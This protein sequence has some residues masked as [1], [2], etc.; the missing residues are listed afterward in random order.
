MTVDNFYERQS[1]LTAAK[2]E[3]YK[4]YIEGY[5]PRLLIQ[6]GTCLI[7][8]LF[9]GAGK[10]GDK[11]G[12]PLVLID[13]SKYILSSPKLQ[14]KQIQIL[15]NDHD[16]DNIQNLNWVLAKIEIEANIQIFKT[17]NNKF[18]EL[19]P[20]LIEKL[21]NSNIPK[22]F[23]LDPFTYSNIKMKHLKQL[24]ALP[25]TEI[26]LFLPIFHSYR[27]ASDKTM[28]GDHKTRLFI[29]EFTTKGVADYE[30][31]DEFMFSVKEK[32]LKKLS[33]DFVRP[34]LLNDGA[35]KNSLFLLTKHQAGM[36]LMNKIA[37][38]MSED[39]SNVNIKTKNQLSLFGV[40]ISSKYER[41]KQLLISQLKDKEK[42]TNNEIVLFTIKKEFL[43]KHGK[44]VITELFNEKKVVIYNFEGN[45]IRN[46]TQWNI[47][48]KITKRRYFK[49]EKLV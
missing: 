23:F 6:F 37:L 10:N 1:A 26:L 44:Q 47:A 17:S 35:K 24:M 19:L 4:K 29:E 36:L 21:K 39:G 46:R 32:I 30:N 22:F 12:S 5:L 27:F 3:I 16:K 18:E 43:P 20:I 8:D 41:F 13:R 11:D 28:S 33:L 34:V 7:A 40:E 49:W 9:C 45:E 48:E 42:M 25:Y 15:F 31:I 14:D 38:K 2:I